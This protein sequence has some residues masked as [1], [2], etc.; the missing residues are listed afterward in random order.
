MTTPINVFTPALKAA[1]A[2]LFKYL[3]T[4]CFLVISHDGYW[5]RGDAVDKA[6]QVCVREGASRAK[7]ATVLL[8]LG[9][10]TPEIDKAGYVVRDAG[11]HNINVIERIRLGAL[12]PNQGGK[13]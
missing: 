8:I 13:L 5:G 4:S 1:E 2:D 6:A 7:S 12:I 9:D 10:Q 11:S 3:N